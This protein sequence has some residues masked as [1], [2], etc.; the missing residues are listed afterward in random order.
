MH[1]SGIGLPRFDVNTDAIFIHEM[2]ANIFP[3]DR[4]SLVYIVWKLEFFARFFNAER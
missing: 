3:T 2:L 1:F 4:P